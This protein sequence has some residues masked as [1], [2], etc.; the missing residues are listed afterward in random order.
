VPGRISYSFMGKNMNLSD[1]YITL[2]KL[3]LRHSNDFFKVFHDPEI[4]RF[5]TTPYPLKLSWVRNYIRNSMELYD[6]DE[7]YTWAIFTK[8]T[9]QFVGVAVLKNIDTKNRS[10]RL[11]YSVGQKYRN[12]GF[13][14]MAVKLILDFT[15]KE[16]NLNRIEI[17][18]DGMDERS[19]TLLKDIGAT[20]EGK[21]RSAIDRNGNFQDLMLYSILQ[22]E[23]LPEE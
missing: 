17:R 22:K 21:L 16:L 5:S 8:V 15:F 3:T 13:T 18:I 23:Y 9:G 4:A 1:N 12:R 10:A 2:K 6:K 11:G 19:I 7:K 20:Y 14:K